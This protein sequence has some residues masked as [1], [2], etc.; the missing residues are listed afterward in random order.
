MSLFVL[1][2]PEPGVGVGD[3]DCQLSCSLHNQ[4]PVLGGDIVGDFSTVSPAD[5]MMFSMRTCHN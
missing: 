2:T 3:L 1:F 4:L 5:R